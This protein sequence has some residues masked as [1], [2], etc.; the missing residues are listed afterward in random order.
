MTDPKMVEC[1]LC[2]TAWSIECAPDID[3]ELLS[4]ALALI[5]EGG[6]EEFIDEVKRRLRRAIDGKRVREM[7][8]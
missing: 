2:E 3:H 8:K 4:D 1:P 6:D 7:K 5:V